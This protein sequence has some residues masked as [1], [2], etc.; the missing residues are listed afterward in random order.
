[1]QIA[2]QLA[3]FVLTLVVLLVTGSRAL[4]NAEKS[5]RED[6]HNHR[7]EL[8]E[9]RLIDQRN[10]GEALTGVRTKMFEIEIWARDEL[11]KYALRESVHTLGGR[12]EQQIV[13]SEERVTGAVA[14]LKQELEKMDSK[15]DVAARRTI[16]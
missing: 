7:K 6:I 9:Q 1:M 13:Q 15:L 8:D 11:T 5:I 3:S 10:M 4:S 14:G 16:G 2:I 12:L